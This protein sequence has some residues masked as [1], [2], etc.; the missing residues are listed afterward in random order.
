MVL[1]RWMYARLD[2]TG[3]RNECFIGR[4]SRFMVLA[5]KDKLRGLYLCCL[6]V[7]IPKCEVRVLPDI[8]WAFGK[9]LPEGRIFD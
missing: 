7:V 4:A 8:H 3:L 9:R 2:S 1:R 5:A 6:E